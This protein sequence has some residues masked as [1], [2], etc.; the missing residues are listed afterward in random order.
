MLDLKIVGINNSYYSWERAVRAANTFIQKYPDRIGVRN[1]VGYYNPVLD[2]KPLYV[3]R[4]KS[5]IM[6]RGE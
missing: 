5:S 2:N 4:T 1:G 6:V 3:Y